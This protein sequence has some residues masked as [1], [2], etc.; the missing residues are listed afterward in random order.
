MLI[1][2][3][4]G[5][6][7]SNLASH[8]LNCEWNVIG[9]DNFQTGNAE[10]VNRIASMASDAFDFVEGDIRDSGLINK[11]VSECSSVVHLA[12]Q[13]SVIR[14]MADPSE[15]VSINV[16]GFVSVAKAAAK[17]K[18]K[19]FIY[20]SSCAVYGDC[21]DIP[22][23]EC[24]VAR[25]LSPYAASKLSDEFFALALEGN[26]S[27][28][29]PIGFRF[30]N[31]YGPW[32][33][34]GGAYAAVIPKWIS[35]RLAGQAPVIFGDGTAVRDFCYVG[36]ICRLISHICGKDCKDSGVYNVGTGKGL[37][38]IELDEVIKT[39]LGHSGLSGVKLAPIFKSKRPGEILKSV[40]DPTRLES[41]FGFKAETTINEGVRE[42][43]Q[44]QYGVFKK[45]QGI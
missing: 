18:I 27:D 10:N 5:F 33:D 11:L 41:V 34:P 17:N 6:I 31:I 25:P 37:S 32:Q 13:P 38:L 26:A 9:L 7:G 8:A 43:L 22:L 3:M 15:T 44:Q 2:G 24:A 14:S 20:A 19:H 39:E 45:E 4:A 21:E 30:F 36:D 29:K 35:K 1:T 28:F 16:E 12:A 42:I 23:Q 40:S